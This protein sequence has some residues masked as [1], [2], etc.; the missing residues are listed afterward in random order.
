LK[1]QEQHLADLISKNRRSCIFGR[2]SSRN[3]FNS[4]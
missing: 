1:N 4:C 3:V 2:R